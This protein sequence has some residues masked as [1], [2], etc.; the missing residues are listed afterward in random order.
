[1]LRFQTLNGGSNCNPSPNYNS[2]GTLD[3][4][5][6]KLLYNALTTEDSSGKLY[7]SGRV[8]K[9][10]LLIIGFTATIIEILDLLSWGK[11]KFLPINWVILVVVKI[12]V[13]IWG[14]ILKF[15]RPYI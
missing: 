4:P 8:T 3:E 15:K 13:L 9:P 7:K 11:P 6:E 12:K 1:M 2:I 5:L 14:L 10:I